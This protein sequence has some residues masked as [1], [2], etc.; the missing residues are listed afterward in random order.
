MCGPACVR[1]RRE[2]FRAPSEG[3]EPIPAES[4]ELQGDDTRKARFEGRNGRLSFG[5]GPLLCNQSDAGLHGERSAQMQQIERAIGAAGAGF[6][7][8]FC[9]RRKAQYRRRTGGSDD[10]PWQEDWN[11]CSVRRP[12][13]AP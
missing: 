2:H 12:P 4:G 3:A 6:R 13:T 7:K 8:E 10:G 5:F 9:D 11:R 1:M